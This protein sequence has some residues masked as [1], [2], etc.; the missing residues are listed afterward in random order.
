MIQ[1]RII[2]VLCLCT[3]LIT[4]HAQ[5]KVVQPS[6]SNADRAIAYEEFRRGVQSFYRG[7]FNESIFLF[8]KALSYIP[9]EALILDWLGKAYYRSGLEG[10]AISQWTE[11]QAE[12]YGGLLLKNKIEMLRDRASGVLPSKKRFVESVSFTALQ[13]D[14]V[15]FRQPLSVLPLTDGGFWLTAYGTNEVLRFNANGLITKRVKGPIAGFDRPFD[16]IALADGRLAVSEFSADRISILSAEGAFVSSFGKTGHANGELVGPQFLASDSYGNIFVSDFGNARIVVFSPKGEALFSFGERSKSFAGF[17][18]P[19]GIAIVDDLVYVA[20]AIKGTIFVFDTAGN[21]MYP[22]IPKD[23]VKG[24]ESLRA[25]NGNLL[26]CTKNQALYVTISDATVVPLAGLGNAPIRLTAV[27]PDAND[28]LLAIDYHN[29]AVHILSPVNELAGGLFLA[30]EHVYS[31]RFPRVTLDVRVLNRDGKQIVGLDHRNFFVS[32]KNRPASEL[33]LVGAGYLNQ[34]FDV[35]FILPRAPQSRQEKTAVD[36]AIVE[37]AKLMNRSAKIHVV[38]ASDKA[39]DGGVFSP[40]LLESRPLVRRGSVST[41][42][43]FDSALRLA[44]GKLMTSQPKRAVVYFNYSSLAE[45]SFARY[46]LY[47][48]AAYMKNN[49]ILFYSLNFNRNAV[50]DELRYLCEETEGKALYVYAEE[51]LNPLVQHI[52]DYS[53]GCYRLQYSS[54]LPTDFGHAYLPVEV[55]VRYLKRS[56]RDETGYFAPLK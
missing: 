48:L 22:L 27:S 21:Y 28:N 10:V 36:N 53:N 6:P 30:I 38:F 33:T 4:V 42:W 47:D 44:A 19:A 1:K 8:E 31:D 3:A 40:Q 26:A 15:L 35:S 46:N 49:G 20:D 55:E 18:A 16:I 34:S 9:G 32:E 23:S 43:H 2:T 12:G 56:G 13:T 11:A 52:R 50:S 7:N 45:E 37:I 5:S 24:I 39:L 29:E 41:Q 14:T 54:T 17:I 51:G 25:W